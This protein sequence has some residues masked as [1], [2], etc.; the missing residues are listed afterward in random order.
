MKML[1]HTLR[2]AQVNSHQGWLM[3]MRPPLV[4]IYNTYFCC[5]A[6]KLLTKLKQKIQ[7]APPNAI[8]AATA[9]QSHG[10]HFVS[11]HAYRV[12]RC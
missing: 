10:L 8:A 5:L 4:A 2:L 11:K 9:G 1:M 3:G 12:T 6:V 7:I